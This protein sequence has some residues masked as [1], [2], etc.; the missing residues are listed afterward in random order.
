MDEENKILRQQL[1]EQIN[2][3]KKLSVEYGQL[4][5]KTE[6]LEQENRKLEQENQ[7]LRNKIKELEKFKK[8]VEN[9]RGW[10]IIKKL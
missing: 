3:H 7:E 10:N 2:A 4:L 6:D 1:E 9:S 8:E 5:F